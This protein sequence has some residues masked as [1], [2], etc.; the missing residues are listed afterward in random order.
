MRLLSS[1]KICSRISGGKRGT[2]ENVGVVI[3]G[4]VKGFFKC[5]DVRMEDA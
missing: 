5:K 1:S 4:I 2:V 3:F